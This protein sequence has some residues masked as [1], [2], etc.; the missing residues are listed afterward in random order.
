MVDVKALEMKGISKSFGGVHAL[1]NVHYNA[2][3][4]KVNV[5]MGENGAGKSTL[6][7]VL[8]GVISSDAGEILIDGQPVRSPCQ[9]ILPQLCG[10]VP[11][12]PV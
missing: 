2:Y 10:S 8:A 4:G 6:M 1:T 11:D 3:R 12:A 5:L 9:R 7:R